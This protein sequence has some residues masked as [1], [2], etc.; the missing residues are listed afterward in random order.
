MPRLT[1][2]DS[3]FSDPDCVEVVEEDEVDLYT[4]VFNDNTAGA[5]PIALE[6]TPIE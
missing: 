4:V 1:S 6:C 2:S 5:I 3:P